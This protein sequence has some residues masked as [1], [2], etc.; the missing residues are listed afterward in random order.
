MAVKNNYR[1]DSLS[2]NID[3]VHGIKELHGTFMLINASQRADR[4]YWQTI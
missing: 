1:A 4:N 2:N 3:E